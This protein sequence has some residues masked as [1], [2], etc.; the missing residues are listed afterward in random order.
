VD[1]LAT[2]RE[3]DPVRSAGLL[4][5]GEV[6]WPVADLRVDWHDDPVAELR[7]LWAVWEPQ[8]EDYVTR[9]LNPEGAPSFGVAGD[10]A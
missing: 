9:A 2:G 1:A 8:L 7:A 3:A 5:G 10:E 4:L 6:P